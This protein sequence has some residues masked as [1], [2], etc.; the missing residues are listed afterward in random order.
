[1]AEATDANTASD[2][3]E[4]NVPPEHRGEAISDYGALRSQVDSALTESVGGRSISAEA[5]NQVRANLERSGVLPTFLLDAQSREQLFVSYDKAGGRADGTL[6]EVELE[7]A[8]NDIN[9]SPY[10]RLLAQS[11]LR[12]FSNMESG[13]GQAGISRYDLQ[14]FDRRPLDNP[15]KVGAVLNSGPP[16]DPRVSDGVGNLPTAQQLTEHGIK[17]VRISLNQDNAPDANEDGKPDNIEKWKALLITYQEAD[18]NVTINFPPEFAPGFEESR[19]A[20][21]DPNY[22]YYYLLDHTGA[23]KAQYDDWKSAYMR[24]LGEVAKEL[25]PWIDN[26]EIGNEPDQLM[27]EANYSAMSPHEFGQLVNDA[28]DVVKRND[29]SGENRV[30][31]GGLSGGQYLQYL[32]YMKDS[33]GGQLKFDSLALHPYAGISDSDLRQLEDWITD[34]GLTPN[35]PDGKP[36]NILIT[37]TDTRTPADVSATARR[38]D[39]NTMIA[40]Y[41]FFWNKTS[42]DKQPGIFDVDNQDTANEIRRLTGRPRRN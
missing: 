8:V 26:Y 7:T 12:K 31:I 9:A 32:N 10:V 15:G 30:V 33:N 17:A 24:K 35:N 42:D 21:D 18:I 41:Y 4:K 36:R 29:N 19:G 39:S 5:L 14:I 22:P 6:T 37:E 28:Y 34:G 38:F 23:D 25:G 2:S 20:T 27:S 3:I 1:M 40:G 11:M 16:D 13:D